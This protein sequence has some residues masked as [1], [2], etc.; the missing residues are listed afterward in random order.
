[1]WV[2]FGSHNEV[3]IDLEYLEFNDHKVDKYEASNPQAGHQACGTHSVSK[4]HC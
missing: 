3:Q 2:D 1:M 4:H